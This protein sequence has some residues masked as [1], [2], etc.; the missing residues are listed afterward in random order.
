MAHPHHAGDR[1]A[2]D[3]SSMPGYPARTAREREILSFVA[4]GKTGWKIAIIIDLAE[5]TRRE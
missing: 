2:L 3:A 5:P 1:A 4:E